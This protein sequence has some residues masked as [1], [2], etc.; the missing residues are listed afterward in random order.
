MNNSA[1][2]QC[3]I[4]EAIEAIFPLIWN[5]LLENRE[6]TPQEKPL[7]VVLG[8]MPGSGKSILIEKLETELNA[9]IIPINGD[10]FR[11]YH[12]NFK[13]IYRQYQGDYPKYTSEFSNKMV[14]RVIKEACLNRFNMVIEGTFRTSEVPIK[15]LSILK[16]QGYQTKA[17]LIAVNKTIAWK[18]TIERYHQ[19]LKNGYYARKVDEQTFN[20]IADHLAQNAKAVLGSDCIDQFEVYSREKTLFNSKTDRQEELEQI[21]NDEL[22]SSKEQNEIY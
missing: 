8:G 19:D 14:E 21:I 5:D 3:L 18:S 13:T 12:P 2:D 10:D 22:N 20:T 7:G 6:I 4:D 16:K 9:N 11:I 17:M 1:I 15:T